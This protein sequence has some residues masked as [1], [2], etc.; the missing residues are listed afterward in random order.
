MNEASRAHDHVDVWKTE[1]PDW[2]CQWRL[3]IQ[4]VSHIEWRL[5]IPACQ[6]ATWASG[7][8]LGGVCQ[9]HTSAHVR[10]ASIET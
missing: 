4:D 9:R 2:N 7:L 5:I 3:Q 10:P 1:C 6:V 8:D